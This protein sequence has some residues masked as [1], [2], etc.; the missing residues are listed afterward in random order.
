MHRETL[1]EY[2]TR[3]NSEAPNSAYARLEALFD[4]LDIYLP[5]RPEAFCR[6]RQ[7]LTRLILELIHDHNTKSLD[8]AYRNLRS[9]DHAFQSGI[10]DP[11]EEQVEARGV[12]L[13]LFY[14]VKQAMDEALPLA[15]M[16]DMPKASPPLLGYID[17]FSEPKSARL[18]AENLC[19]FLGIT[20]EKLL[21][22]SDP[23]TNLG[24][25][26]WNLQRLHIT[27]RG[28]DVVMA[29]KRFA[30]E[31]STVPAT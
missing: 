21:S 28:T 6:W 30:R 4:Q 27:P 3:I 7:E 26:V 14:L 23:L 22:L 5:R 25:A 12:L 13:T 20:T 18:E 15:E 2:A 17:E 31:P 8:A 9:A 1:Q 24:L 10:Q 29:L 16:A 11:T 19:G